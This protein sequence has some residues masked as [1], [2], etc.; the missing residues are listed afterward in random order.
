MFEEVFPGVSALISE[1]NSCNIYLLHGKENVLIDTGLEH[2]VVLL[3]L[4]LEELGVLPQSVSMILFTHGHADHIGGAKLFPKAVTW[5]SRHD[6]K[7][8]NERDADFTVAKWSNQTYYPDIKKFFSQ[9][10]MFK[11]NSLELEVIE[12]PGHTKGSVCFH[13]S[14]NKLLFSG[15]TLFK[16]A[17]GRFDLPSANKDELKQ[18]IEAISR[19]D[20]NL[21]LPGHMDILKGKQREN[22]KTAQK[23]LV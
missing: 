18:S 6:G 2:D 5:M 13:D 3:E 11:I 20:F 19:L 8:V 23:F 14:K 17:V 7:L 22:I 10:Q 21:L 9:K 1:A 4:A 12:T 16:G 15:D